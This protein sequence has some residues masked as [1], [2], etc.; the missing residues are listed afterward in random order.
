MTRLLATVA[1]VALVALVVATE[2]SADKP[3]REPIFLGDIELG[4]YA[5]LSSCLR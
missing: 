5:P 2:A 3:I 1:S 4:A